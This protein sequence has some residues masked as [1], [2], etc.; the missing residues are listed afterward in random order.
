MSFKRR[1]MQLDVFSRH[2]MKGNPLAV[3]IDGDGLDDATM[4]AFARWTN[5]SET[6]FLLPPTTAEADYRVRIFTPRQEL[7]FAGHPSV[8]SAYV[9]VETGLVT[10]GKTHLVQQC[11][12]GL[13]PVTIEHAGPDRMI[14]V[15]A[16]VAR[17]HNVSADIRQAIGQA[18]GLPLEDAQIRLADNGPHW[19][20]CDLREASQVRALNPDLATIA[21]LCERHG[22]IGVSA[23]G[24]ESSGAAQMAVRA[25]CPAD[26]IP[27]DP[28][29]GSVNAAIMAFL[30]ERGDESYGFDY[31]ASQGREV[32][33]DGQ[34]RVRRDPASGA[35]TI[36]GQCAAV[37]RGELDLAELR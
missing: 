29:T 25:F 21:A 36:G 37:I 1:F 17:L 35:I 13:L 31:L 12:A 28:V 27:E 32:G 3:V 15:Q 30:A 14:H 18:I 16:P 6:T 11:A 20:V 34:V 2:P 4:R 7:P 24:R 19:W 10:A 22:A 8:G 23:F 26:G 5:L 33:R 9:A